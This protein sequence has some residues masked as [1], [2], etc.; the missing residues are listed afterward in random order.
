MGGPE[1]EERVYD[2]FVV[3]SVVLDRRK[4]GTWTVAT[5]FREEESAVD[6]VGMPVMDGLRNRGL[7]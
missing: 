4:I 7:R 2:V 5:I 3:E 6:G 1:V